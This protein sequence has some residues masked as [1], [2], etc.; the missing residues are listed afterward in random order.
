LT[1]YFTFTF[2]VAGAVALAVACFAAM[3]SSDLSW[4]AAGDGARRCPARRA[5]TRPDACPH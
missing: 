4:K 5:V 2:V 1:F 3:L